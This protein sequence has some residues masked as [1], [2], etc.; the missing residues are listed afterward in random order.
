M[1]TLEIISDFEKSIEKIQ[2]VM[3]KSDLPDFKKSEHFTDHLKH[4][5]DNC[6]KLAV[7]IEKYNHYIQ[8][9]NELKTLLMSSSRNIGYIMEVI[10]KAS[11][12]DFSRQSFQA[13]INSTTTCIDLIDNYV[14]SNDFISKNLI[15]LLLVKSMR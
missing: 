5:H 11:N 2:K 1:N 15:K 4:L 9:F 8:P 6:R 7:N 13:E 3:E 10:L 12:L 14:N